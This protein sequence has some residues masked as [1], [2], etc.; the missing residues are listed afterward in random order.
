MKKPLYA[1]LATTVAAFV[2]ALSTAGTAVAQSTETAIVAGGCF[3]CT[4]SD[5]DKIEGVLETT[6]GY[7]GGQVDN[8]TYKQVS[9][10]GTGHTEAV[11]IVFDPEVVDYETLIDY[12]WMTVDPTVDDRQ[13]CDVGSQYRPEIFTQGDMQRQIALASLHAIESSKPFDDPIKVKITDAS[14]FY[15]AEDYHQDY[16][17][18]NPIRYKFYRR[19]CGRDKRLQELWG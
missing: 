11:R 2:I 14:T 15:P 4:E 5:F 3:W 9:A 13:F 12:Y 17:T 6:S 18:K 10:G 1:Y 7:I 16:H 8:P 19:G